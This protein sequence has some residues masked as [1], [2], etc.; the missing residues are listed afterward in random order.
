MVKSGG[1]K[2]IILTAGQFAQCLAINEGPVWY[3]NIPDSLNWIA[4]FFDLLF[5]CGLHINF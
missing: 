5:C 1:L 2:L 4:D 3:Y